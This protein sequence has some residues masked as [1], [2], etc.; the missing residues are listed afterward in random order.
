M[1]GRDKGVR[2]RSMRLLR[3]WTDV[4]FV[5]RSP[6][7]RRFLKSASESG[8]HSAPLGLRSRAR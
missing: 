4:R 3:H 5:C 8:A 1:G 7:A 2:P 6:D